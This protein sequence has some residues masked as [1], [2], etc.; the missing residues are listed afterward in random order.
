MSP[1]LGRFPGEGAG[2]PLQCSSASL[3]AQSVKNLPAMWETWVQSLG[4][5]DPLEENM[6]AHSDTCAWRIP[7]DREAR[8]AI[9]H[10]VTESYTPKQSSR[11]HTHTHTHTYIFPSLSLIHMLSN[12]I[13]GLFYT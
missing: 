3:M 10:V 8:W 5:E 4:W 12:I 6:A 7:M 11:I 13:L 2:Y 1:G 9:V